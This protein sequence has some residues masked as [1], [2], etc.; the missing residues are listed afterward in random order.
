LAV[1][2]KVAAVQGWPLSEAPLH[3]LQPFHVTLPGK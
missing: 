1:I 2:S 3:V